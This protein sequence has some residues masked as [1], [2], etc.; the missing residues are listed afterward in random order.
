MF[1]SGSEMRG[2]GKRVQRLQ[3]VNVCAAQGRMLVW[4]LKGG[5]DAAADPSGSPS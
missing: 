5:V 3:P 4:E 2:G 1:K